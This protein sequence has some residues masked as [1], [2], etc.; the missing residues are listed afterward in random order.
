M[1]RNWKNER[2]SVLVY[3]NGKFHLEVQALA[4]SSEEEQMAG[5][6]SIKDDKNLI[7]EY[8]KGH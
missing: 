7:Q 6:M 8:T 3:A 1:E 2:L 5:M 4:S